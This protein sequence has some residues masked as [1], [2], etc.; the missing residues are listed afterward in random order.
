MGKKLKKL[1]RDGQDL[2]PSEFLVNPLVGV[3]FK[4][5][6]SKVWDG[7]SFKEIGGDMLASYVELEADKFTKV[8]GNTEYRQ[9]VSLLSSGAKSL[10]LWLLYEAESGRDWIWINKKRY[11]KEN[12]VS[13][14]NTYKKAIEELGKV[15]I[16]NKHHKYRD[17][18]W[19]NPR[20]FFNGNRAKKFPKNV[21]VVS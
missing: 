7:K 12:L 6:V 18:Y 15:A 20:L 11:M 9:L 5:L 4:I 10:Y 21:E 13:S 2:D 17:V 14:L 3:D 19:L 8:Y 16:I 1:V